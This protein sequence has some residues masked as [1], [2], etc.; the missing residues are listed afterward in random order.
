MI[1]K[2]ASMLRREFAGYN[3]KSFTSDLMAGLTVTAVALPL[4]LAFGVS[5]GADAAAGLIT[6]II[7]GLII[8]A[9]SGASFQISGP[10]GTMSAVLVGIIAKFGL[11]GVFVV[12]FCAGIL[13]LLCAVLKLGR[14]VNMIPRPVITGFTTGIAL[15]IALGQVDNFFGTSSVGENALAK[16]GSFIT[17]K[18]GAIHLPTL[19][20]GLLVVVIMIVWPKKWNARVPSSLVGIIVAAVVSAVLKLDVAYVGEIPKQLFLEQRLN[21]ANIEWA[22]IFEYL[23]PAVSVAALAMIESLLCGASASR[24]K[25]E[26]FD[27]D[28]ELI[29]Q[30]VGNLIIPFFGGVPATAAIARTSVAIKSG[31]RTRL[32]GI[33]H[34]LGLLASMFLLGGVMAKLPMAALAGVL[35]M[36]A[37]R[38]NEWSE[39]KYIFRHK[40]W[41]AVAK[42]LVTMVATVVFDLTIAIVIGI[43]L[44]MLMFIVRSTNLS[45]DVSDDHGNPGPNDDR[46]IIYINGPV[47]FANVGT[48]VKKLDE[49]RAGSTQLIIS[50][51]GVPA[52]DTSG[53]ECILEYLE[54]LEHEKVE[55]AVCGLNDRVDTMLTKGG[56]GTE[57]T[58]TRFDSLD[59]ALAAK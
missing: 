44:S 28:Q 20:I 35:M 26:P 33:I 49:A 45:V 25:N 31:A 56:L 32:C 10:T 18:A 55:V 6:A 5:C 14:F 42:F 29:A 16:F 59:K 40:F 27:A 37:W 54:Q 53:V 12:S 22:R 52:V 2:Y 15:I 47:F 48:L 19:L 21:F 13:I 17:G 38:M 50:L 39:I 8:G 57:V 58:V 36:T 3:A 51:R 41:A 23:S 46:R 7:A 1:K 30:G 9:L 4:A 11:D 34:A 43:V 24:M